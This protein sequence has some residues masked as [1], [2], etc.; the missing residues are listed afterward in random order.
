MTAT[1]QQPPSIIKIIEN[2]AE[3]NVISQ[4]Q[5]EIVFATLA[6]E[7]KV[8]I[9]ACGL[10]GKG[11]ST[12][13]NGIIGEK[14]FKEG[15]TL[16][17]ETVEVG[18]KEKI[19]SDCNA[20]VIAYDTPGFH[21]DEDEYTRKIKEHSKDVDVLIYCISVEPPRAVMDKDI[22]LLKLLKSALDADIWKHCV[23][24]LTFANTIISTLQQQGIKDVKKNFK[25]KLSHWKGKVEVALKEAAIMNPDLIP[26]VTAGI[27]RKPSFFNDERSW[28]SELWF[29]ILGKLSNDGQMALLLMNNERI[30]V[31]GDVE[32]K[33]DAAEQALIMPHGTW[34][35]KHKI[36][37]LSGGAGAS[38]VAGL[39][40]A[41]TGAT[42]GALAIGIPSFGVAAGVG[43]VLGA[44]IGGGIGVGAATATTAV[45][46]VHKEKQREKDNS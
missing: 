19:V 20:E 40:G 39:A 13:L 41:G 14:L 22:K 18:K 44:L 9:M 28:L 34:F 30:K 45:I 23:I 32:P 38:T 36:K 3:E 12:I 43:L 29:T 4:E 33:M 11:K 7:K 8:H 2:L 10:T 42:I 15:D 24:V 27:S 1:Q 46:T 35:Q 26:I 5:K 25:I 6:G 31:T 37:I 16:N 21:K 17:D